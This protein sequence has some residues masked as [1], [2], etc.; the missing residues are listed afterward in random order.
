MTVDVVC[1]SGP[2]CD[3]ANKVGSRDEGDDQGKDKDSRGFDDPSGKHGELGEACFPDDKEYDEDGSKKKR[4]KDM[5]R[6]PWIHVAA[7]LHAG[8]WDREVSGMKLQC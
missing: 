2:E 1:L 8:H 6:G 3:Q 4:Y 5:D 7:P